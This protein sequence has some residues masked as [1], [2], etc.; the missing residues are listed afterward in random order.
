MKL[1]LVQP[2]LRLEPGEHNLTAI[3]VLMRP[4]RAQLGADDVVLLPEHWTTVDSAEVYEGLVRDIAVELGCHVVG[5]SHHQQRA[6]GAVNAGSVF[7]GGGRLVGRYEKLRPYA[8]E[9]QVVR[10]GGLR[11]E[12]VLAGRRVLVLICSDFWFADVVA[13]T[14]L[15]PDLVLVPA[16]SVTRKPGPDYSARSGA[17]SR[18]RV[19]TSTGST[20]ASATGGTRRRCRA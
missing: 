6:G 3:T 13:L 4:I 11:G 18:W 17:T 9:R 10:P 2:Q 14:T 16:L 5:G 15:V 19:P 8:A 12:L 1:V 20:S 7:D